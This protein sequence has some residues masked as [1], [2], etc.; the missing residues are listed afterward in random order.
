M[1]S[2][3]FYLAM[4]SRMGD[5][6]M[7]KLHQFAAYGIAALLTAVLASASPAMAKD[8]I[9]CHADVIKQLRGNS[10]HI[11]G[12]GISG[13]H[14]YACHWEATAEGRINEHYHNKRTWKNSAP[15]RGVTV[16]L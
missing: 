12:V 15:I 16:D 1:P 13:R 8:C 9:S 7:N 3:W 11:Q 10:H 4:Q 5:L 2:N 14:C 6:R